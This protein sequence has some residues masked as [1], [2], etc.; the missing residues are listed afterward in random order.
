MP[1]QRVPRYKLLL[2]DL[3]KNTPQTHP[4]HT[5]LGLACQMVAGIALEINEKIRSSEKTQA[6]LEEGRGKEVVSCSS[7]HR[8]RTR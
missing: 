1:V 3:L 6:M 5:G 7:Y 2:E 4:D 8:A